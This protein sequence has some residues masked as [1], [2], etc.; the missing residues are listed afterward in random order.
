MET[1]HIPIVAE[2]EIESRK[3]IEDIKKIQYRNTE[4]AARCKIQHIT[5]QLIARIWG[6]LNNTQ[7]R[8]RIKDIAEEQLPKITQQIKR[9]YIKD[10]TLRKIEERRE[11]TIDDKSR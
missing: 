5:Q 1:R 4:N 8:N 3:G 2:M 7:K 10:A 11:K 6:I 9:D